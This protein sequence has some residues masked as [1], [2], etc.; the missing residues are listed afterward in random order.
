MLERLTSRHKTRERTASSYLG[1][2]VVVIR[3]AYGHPRQLKP[4]V[5]LDLCNLGDGF[6]VI[7][8]VLLELIRVDGFEFEVMVVAFKEGLKD[9]C[10]KK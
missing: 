2:G 5:P 7:D 3:F 1:Q 4:V 10:R 6:E 9:G 8:E